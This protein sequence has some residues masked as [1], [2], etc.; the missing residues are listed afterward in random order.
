MTQRTVTISLSPELADS[1][2]RLAKDEGRTR[3][4]FFREAARQYIERTQRW[5]QIFAMGDEIAAR[6]GITDDDIMRIVKEE[7]RKSRK[8]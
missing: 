3:S 2:D 5:D 8:K 7:R 6:T 1:V 4:E